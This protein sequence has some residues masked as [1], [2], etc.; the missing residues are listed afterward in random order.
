MSEK[1]IE[2]CREMGISAALEC[3]RSGNGGHVWI[4]FDSSIPAS[5]ARKLG[6]VIL[7]RTMEHLI[8]MTAFFPTRTPC[9]KVALGI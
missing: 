8:P 2:T 1:S 5:L 6:C 7:T 3:S 9:P 4:F